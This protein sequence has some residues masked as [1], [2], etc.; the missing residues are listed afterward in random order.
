MRIAFAV[1]AVALIA[2][3]IVGV[4]LAYMGQLHSRF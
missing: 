1:V 4:M 3:A 2:S